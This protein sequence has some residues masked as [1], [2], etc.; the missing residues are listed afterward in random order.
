MAN[1]GPTSNGSQFFITYGPAPHLDGGYTIFGE[2][3]DGMAVA[4][5]LT[6]RDPQAGGELPPGDLLIDV[7]IEEQ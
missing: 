5:D 1:S 6:P 2:V 7:R 3:V 4:E